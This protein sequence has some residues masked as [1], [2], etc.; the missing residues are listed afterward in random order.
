MVVSMLVSLCLKPPVLQ[1]PS[2]PVCLPACLQ[3]TLPRYLR[4]DHA[5]LLIPIPPAISSHLITF[6]VHNN[7]PV[8]HSLPLSLGPLQS[9]T[10]QKL[11]C[12]RIFG[13][14]GLNC[15]FILGTGITIH[16]NA[17]PCCPD[18]K[19]AE[20]PVAERK[21][22]LCLVLVL[23]VIF[24]HYIS[25]SP[26]RQKSGFITASSSVWWYS[27]RGHFTC[28]RSVIIEDGEKVTFIT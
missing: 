23:T 6:K 3:L 16:N 25:P 14:G 12:E 22:T 18:D 28:S 5:A 8:K 4:I 20:F 15:M 7:K 27:L 21:L 9:S 13:G 11:V 1:D 19:T 24:Q 2:Q 10:W 26:L 17:D